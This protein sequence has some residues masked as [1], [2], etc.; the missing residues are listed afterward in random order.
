MDI[1]SSLP[2]RLLIVDDEPSV[3]NGLERI[4]RREGYAIEKTESGEEALRILSAS[5]PDVALIDLILP[6]V[7][8]MELL[9][10]AKALDPYIEVIIMTGHG[11]IE[12]AI[13]AMKKGALDFLIKPFENTERII[14]SVRKALERRHL[15]VKAD[16]LEEALEEKY[17]FENIVGSSPGMMEI[18]RL[19]R[20][21]S[22]SEATVLILGESGTGKELIARAIHYH[23]P[24]KDGPFVPVDCGALPEGIMESELFGHEKGAY[25][26]A[27]VSTR[28]LIRSA[29]G[30]TI[31]LDEI[32]EVPISLQAK[33]LRTLQEREVRPVGGTQTV[34]V[35]T[36]VIAAS[37]KDLYSEVQKGTF[38]ADLFYRINVVSIRVPPLREKKEDIPLLVAHFIKTKRDH[39]IT[40]INED[41]LQALMS[42]TWP[43]NVRELENALER[44]FALAREHTITLRDLPSFSPEEACGYPP[45]ASTEGRS[46]RT[47]PRPHPNGAPLSLKVYERLALE[48][49]LKEM[50]GDVEKA[51]RALGI[52]KSTLYRK[53]REHGLKIKKPPP[54][55]TK[56]G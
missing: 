16:R 15:R 38:R 35:D 43:G 19:I 12:A 23:S 26:G 55:E 18:F 36:R 3:L 13:E 50:D 39:A 14:L 31:F 41:A 37:N 9:S 42:Y 33:L 1:M 25:T 48:T 40:G 56:R 51:A 44:G 5:P 52:G 53:L 27:H 8:G 17:R 54:I 46:G 6:G 28:G 2:G 49:A 34:K 32:G 22:H 10:R 7:S 11:S 20:Q 30:G 45:R 21:L 24:R 47:D 4:F 29:D